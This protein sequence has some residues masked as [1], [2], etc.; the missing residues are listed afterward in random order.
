MDERRTAQIARNE[1]RFREINERLNAG[2]QQVPDNPELLEF[3]CECGNSACQE[4]V[5][6]TLV[7]YERVRA[8]SRR[9]AVVPGHVIPEAERVVASGDRFEVV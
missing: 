5:R 2:L 3:I 7:E 1:S 9:F 8:D 6:L 4:H